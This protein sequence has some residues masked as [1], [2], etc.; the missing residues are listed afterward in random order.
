[1]FATNLQAGNRI[2]FALKPEKATVR[3]SKQVIPGRMEKS[4]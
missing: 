2:I 4:L 1:M 3:R